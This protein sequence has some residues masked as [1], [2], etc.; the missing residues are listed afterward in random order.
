M[1]LAKMP[2]LKGKQRKAKRVGRGI[3]SGKGSHTTG[4]GQ[5]GQKSRTGKNI[6]VGFEGGQVPLYKKLPK[7]KGFVN[8]SGLKRA[9]VN[10]GRLNDFKEGDKVTPDELVRRGMLKDIP[11]DGVKLLG[12][13]KLSKK[14]NF[15]GFTLSKSARDQVEKLGGLIL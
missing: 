1:K 13:G 14:L 12:G 9:E 7:R 5:K 3:G 8:I 15:E 6:P 11:K 10:L 4:K 2:K